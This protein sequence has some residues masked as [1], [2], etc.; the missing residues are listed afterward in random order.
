MPKGNY[1]ERARSRKLL[2][3]CMVSGCQEPV[4]HQVLDAAGH[5]RGVFC[6][7]CAPKVVQL[8]NSFELDQLVLGEE[9]PGWFRRLVSWL[10]SCRPARAVVNDKITEDERRWR[11]S[12]RA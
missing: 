5:S 6:D 12:G 4:A 7:A 2:K 3:R 11:R 9:Y 10:K 1:V 8:L